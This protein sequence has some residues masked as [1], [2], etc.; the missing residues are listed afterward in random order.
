MPAHS[1]G[2]G[3]PR[4]DCE[5]RMCAGENPGVSPPYLS[6]MAHSLRAHSLAAQ[7]LTAQSLT[8]QS[9]TA[10]SLAAQSLTAH[11]LTAQRLMAQPSGA[12][13]ASLQLS[14]VS[15]ALQQV[16]TPLW[17]VAPLRQTPSGGPLVEKGGSASTW[18]PPLMGWGA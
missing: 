16:S 14:A 1:P 3:G 12:L 18:S 2:K 17:P 10:Q 15:P 13:P 9:F 5:I 4:G 7:S 8:A 6:L 11:S